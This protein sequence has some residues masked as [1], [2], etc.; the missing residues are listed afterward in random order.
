[1]IRIVIDTNIYI[2]AMINRNSRLRLD[3]ILKDNRF[4]ILTDKALVNELFEVINR[5]KFRKYVSA[6]QIDAFMDLLTERSIVIS[7]F[8]KV[9]HSPDPKDDFLLALSMDGSAQYLITG[10]KIDLLDLKQ[11]AT[12]SIL[13][14]TEFLRIYFPLDQSNL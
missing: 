1:M 5:P 4:E 13:S 6:E 8:S 10:N 3:L 12:T 2:S 7:T 9:S 14:L 11:F